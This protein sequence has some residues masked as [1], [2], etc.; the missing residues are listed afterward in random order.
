MHRVI[1]PGDYARQLLAAMRNTIDPATGENL[2]RRGLERLLAENGTPYS[3]EHI[4]KMLAGEPVASEECNEAV[5]AILGLDAE[6][7]WAQAQAEKSIRRFGTG[8]TRM[9]APNDAR[10]RELWERLDETDRNSMIQWAEGVVMR[11]ASERR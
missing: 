5:C 7:F 11:H 2:T 4:R 3:Y 10:M 6:K 1:S 9:A 8:V